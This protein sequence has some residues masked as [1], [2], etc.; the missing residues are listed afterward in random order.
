MEAR[1]ESAVR[2]IAAYDSDPTVL[3]DARSLIPFPALIEAARTNASK[4]HSPD[5]SFARALLSWFKRDFFKWTNKPPCTTLGCNSDG[6]LRTLA[7]TRG[8]VTVGEREGLASRVEVWKC[9]KCG[10]GDI[11]FPRY[12]NPR[13]L[14]SSRN[15]R[16][17]EFANCFGLFCTAVGFDTRYVLDFTDH[18]WVEIYDVVK[19]RWVCMDSCEDKFDHP[20]MY[21]KGWGKKLSYVI[22]VS[23]EGVADVTRRYSRSMHTL[24]MK[25]RRNL[26]S[27]ENLR[28]LIRQKNGIQRQRFRCNESRRKE[29]DRRE[30]EEESFF[31]EAEE[32]GRR[33]KGAKG[34]EA[35]GVVKERWEGRISGDSYWKRSRGEDGKNGDGKNGDGEGEVKLSSSSSS[36]SAASAASVASIT[37][38]TQLPPTPPSTASTILNNR[39]FLDML[40]PSLLKGSSQLQIQLHTT[41]ALAHKKIILLYFSAHWCGPCRNFTPTLSEFYLT[42][43]DIRPDDIEIVFISSDRDSNGFTTYFGTMPWLAVPFESRHLKQAMT[44]RFGVGGIPALVVL[45]AHTGNVVTADGRGDVAG[46]RGDTELCFAAWLGELPEESLDAHDAAMIERVKIE[47]DWERRRRDGNEEKAKMLMVNK[48]VTKEERQ[49]ELQVR[50]RVSVVSDCL[51][52]FG[53]VFVVFFYFLSTIFCLT[54]SLDSENNVYFFAFA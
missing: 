44:S 43:R 48:S 33:A 41:D 16:C 36:S 51:L 21:E 49:A 4:L 45:D 14:L 35:W 38:T 3:S 28:A 8:P 22:A 23:R 37:A 11:P 1:I 32:M 24:E 47:E 29:L 20:G 39:V 12:N 18:V 10:N 7:S 17:G 30:E 46:S 25:S 54:N 50:K 2:T 13:T 26:I 27:E 53:L 40:G 19:D 52:F 34:D 5:L 42:H 31:R 6:A 9:G 15:G